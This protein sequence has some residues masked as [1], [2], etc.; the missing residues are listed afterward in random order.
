M[1]VIM[2]QKSSILSIEIE[3]IQYDRIR[4]ERNLI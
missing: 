2:L 4:I 3:G 1:T